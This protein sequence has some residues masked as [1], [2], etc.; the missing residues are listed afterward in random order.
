MIE[1]RNTRVPG[2]AQHLIEQP[3]ERRK[4]ERPEPIHR[5]EVRR[6]VPVKALKPNCS[7]HARAISRDECIPR[8]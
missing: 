8:Q 5:A 4:M 7:R 6:L 3:T 1:R 2:M